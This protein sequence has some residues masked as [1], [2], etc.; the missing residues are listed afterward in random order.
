MQ[1][2]RRV[3]NAVVELPHTR[4]ERVE[5]LDEAAILFSAGCERAACA[6]LAAWCEERPESQGAWTMH[7]DAL[8]ALGDRPA[9]ED[10]LPRYGAQFPAAAAP[11]WSTP[12][13]PAGAGMV[14]LEGVIESAANLQA[15]AALAPS[16]SILA[17]D[18]GDV[19]RIDFA[20]APLFCAAMRSL[21]R[22]SRRVILANVAELHARLLAV[23]GLPGEVVVLPRRAALASQ[24]AA[25][26][27]R[28][29]E[30]A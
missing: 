20:F 28:M 14:R 8:R 27:A 5:G 9:F 6:L 12:P 3:E 1:G 19:L 13:L 7:F 18:L 25:E 16:R 4:S 10:L 23:S 2:P 26:P 22:Q 30:A 29:L 24:A 21:V 17:L 11:T 15:V